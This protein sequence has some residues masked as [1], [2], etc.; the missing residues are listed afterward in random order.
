MRLMQDGLEL[1][2]QFARLDMVTAKASDPTAE[3]FSDMKE[4]AAGRNHLVKN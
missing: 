2:G 4:V 1:F 3:H